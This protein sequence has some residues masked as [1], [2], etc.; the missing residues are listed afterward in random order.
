MRYFIN[1]SIARHFTHTLF[2]N[3][4]HSW[5]LLPVY[6]SSLNSHYHYYAKPLHS[7]DSH[8]FNRVL[9][10]GITVWLDKPLS[11]VTSVMQVCALVKCGFSYTSTG[12]E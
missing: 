11:A 6:I 12:R 10:S 8:Y 5:I 4:I 3:C 7:T 1:A 2:K 9:I